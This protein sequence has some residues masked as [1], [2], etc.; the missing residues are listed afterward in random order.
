L[1]LLIK[2]YS[3]LSVELNG[4]CLTLTVISSALF[5]FS[6]LVVTTPLL[7]ASSA[8]AVKIL[9]DHVAPDMASISSKS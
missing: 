7:R 6:I 4:F 9:Y 3:R 8:D 2:L 1:H 5:I